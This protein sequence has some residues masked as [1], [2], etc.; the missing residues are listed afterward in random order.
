MVKPLG[1]KALPSGSAVIETGERA[2][3]KIKAVIGYKN[4]KFDGITHVK[5]LF[6]GGRVVS[7]SNSVAVQSLK[8]LYHENGAYRTFSGGQ[9]YITDYKQSKKFKV[10]DR[11]KWQYK[12]V[13]FDRYFNTAVPYQALQTRFTVKGTVNGKAFTF[14]LTSSRLSA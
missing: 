6:Y 5:G 9:G 12:T 14:N 4:K 11:Y 3:M 2:Y 8:G 7:Q 13:D 10:D 1:A